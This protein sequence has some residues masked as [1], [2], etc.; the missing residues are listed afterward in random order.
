MNA[1][2]LE[3]LRQ[4]VVK[5]EKNC[6]LIAIVVALIVSLIAVRTVVSFISVMVSGIIFGGVFSAI[7]THKLRNDF[8]KGYKELIILELFKSMFTDVTFDFQNGIPKSVIEN[9]HMIN[10][11]DRYTSNDY[12]RAKYKNVQFEFSDIEIKEEYTDHDGNR[13]SITIF[14][15]QWYIFDFNKKFKSDIQVCEKAF[16]TAKR[17]NFSDGVRFKKVELE[18]IEF[19]KKFNV[20]AKNDLDAFYVLTPNTMEKIKELSN[21]ITGKLLLCFID[22]KLHIGLYNCKDLF[23]PKLYAKIDL[24]KNTKQAREEVKLITQFIDILDLDNNLFREEV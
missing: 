4:A 5:K 16:I 22:N 10:M 1:L 6:I 14:E 2:E 11:G 23:E 9:T 19:N 18:D 24:D 12:M 7:F 13:R 20:F 3:Q 17:D 8:I 15:G 21:K